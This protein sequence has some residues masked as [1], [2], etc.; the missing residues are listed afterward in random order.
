MSAYP[1]SFYIFL[2]AAK[3]EISFPLAQKR[4]PELEFANS[5]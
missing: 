2:E 5:G 4:I 3:A 1:S